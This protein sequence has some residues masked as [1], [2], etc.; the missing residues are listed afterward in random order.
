MS[1]VAGSGDKGYRLPVAVRDIAKVA[2]VC[3]LSLDVEQACALAPQANIVLVEAASN[4]NPDLFNAVAVA[5]APPYNAN[6][7]SMSW[8]S[9]EFSGEAAYDSSWK[10][11]WRCR[12]A[13]PRPRRH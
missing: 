4:S 10:P 1:A 7:V 3:S 8:G 6:L 9:S 13:R 11:G 12:V 2:V 5:V